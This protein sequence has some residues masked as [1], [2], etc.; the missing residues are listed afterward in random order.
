[1]NYTHSL[2]LLII[3]TCVFQI[4]NPTNKPLQ[5]NIAYVRDEKEVRR[6]FKVPLV[7]GIPSLLNPSEKRR[8]WRRRAIEWVTGCALVFVTLIAESYVCLRAL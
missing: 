8:L 2:C 5:G 6:H 4:H 3:S 1:M 7:V